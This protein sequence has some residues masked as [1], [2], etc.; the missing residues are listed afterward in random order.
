MSVHDALVP[1]A[2]Q[3]V[4]DALSNSLSPSTIVP[5]AARPAIHSLSGQP[6]STEPITISLSLQI[7]LTR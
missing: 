2:E 1:C 6:Y 4:L 3:H 5:D 7:G